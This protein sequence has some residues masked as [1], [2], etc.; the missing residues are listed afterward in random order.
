MW[1]FHKV[2]I[3]NSEVTFH[4]VLRNHAINPGFYSEFTRGG[5]K[6]LLLHIFLLKRGGRKVRGG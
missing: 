5:K 1:P 6:S 2:E 3:C 4:A